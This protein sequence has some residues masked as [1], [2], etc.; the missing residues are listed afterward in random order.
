[1]GIYVTVERLTGG[2]RQRDIHLLPGAFL[3]AV[4]GGVLGGIF[5]YNVSWICSSSPLRVGL[6][7]SNA[8]GK[9]SV[10]ALA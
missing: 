5:T 4:K 3:D 10:H 9:T 6:W 1:M 7:A 8:K 2:F